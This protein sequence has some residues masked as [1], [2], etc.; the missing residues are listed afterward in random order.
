MCGFPSILGGMA[1]EAQTS[2]RP[3]RTSEFVIE[4]EG[5]DG[6]DGCI[7]VA[8]RRATSTCGSMGRK[9]RLFCVGRIG[10]DGVVRIVDW[11]YATA[12]EARAAWP[13]AAIG[14]AGDA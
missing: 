12:E 14:S 5:Y 3:A 10:D 11:G 4:V 7:V 2:D 13:E 6:D 1:T 9:D 8:N